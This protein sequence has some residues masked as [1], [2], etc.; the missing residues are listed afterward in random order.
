MGEK[1][2]D[3]TSQQQVGGAKSI[4]A[5]L[6]SLWKDTRSAL[7]AI[8]VGAVILG[9]GSVTSWLLGL[10]R[11]LLAATV[12][13]A[14][15]LAA[16]WLPLPVRWQRLAAGF[17]LYVSIAVMVTVL[18]PERPSEEPTIGASPQS[19]ST[20]DVVGEEDRYLDFDVPD[21]DPPR[22]MNVAADGSDVFVNLDRI[23]GRIRMRVA[24][25]QVAPISQDPPSNDACS[26]T[27]GWT[28]QSID[29]VASPYLCVETTG[30]TL[31]LVHLENATLA[32]Q[33]PRVMFS[34]SIERQPPSG[35]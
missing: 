25:G 10:P 18:L 24:A 33:P 29:V 9:L 20:F 13:F 4:H 7:V 23:G 35:R 26:A 31:A 5:G 15:G 34:W 19:G 6:S 11:P 30:G 32:A 16:A 14:A 28:D 8:V 12:G 22:N 1:P 2:T 3:A 27:T 17:L 21:G